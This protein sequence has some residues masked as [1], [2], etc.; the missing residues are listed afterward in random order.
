M[1]GLTTNDMTLEQVKAAVRAIP[2]ENHFVW[3]GVD[4][5]DRPATAEEMR[6]G[7]EAAKRRRGRPASSDKTQIAL[8]VDNATL[9]AFR[10]T[11]QGWQSRMNQALGE[12]VKSARG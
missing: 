12:W 3:D 5:D 8:R 7:I 11:G 2:P 10:A 6:A 9:E 1:S 4:E